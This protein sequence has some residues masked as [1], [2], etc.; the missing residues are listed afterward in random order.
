MRHQPKTLIPLFALFLLAGCAGHGQYTSEFKQ[1]AQERM[2]QLK[3]A[4][5]WDM[6][7]QQFLSGDLYKA[8]K[9]VDQS[10]TIS[11]KVAKSHLLRGRILIEMGRLEEAMGSLDKAIELKPEEAEAHYYKG[12]IFER[13]TQP[14]PALESYRAAIEHD[15]TDP[16]YVLAAAEMLIQLRKLDD[17]EQ[18]LGERQADFQHNAGIRQTL[19][20]IAMIRGDTA[21]AA[22]RFKEACTLDPDD[23]GLLEDLAGAQIA[24][25]DYAGA[26]YSLRRALADPKCKDRSD[27]KFLR[28]RA[29]MAIDKPVEAR[30]ILLSLTQEE[31]GMN[32]TRL[33]AALGEA[34]A[35]IGDPI[36]LRE[37]ATRLIGLA[38]RQPVG[39][40]LLARWQRDRGDLAVAVA[41]LDRAIEFAGADP[42]P[43]LLQGL[44][45][46]RLNQPERAASSY[47]LALA[48]DPRCVEAS[49]RLNAITS[50][51]P[52]LAGVDEQP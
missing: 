26:E 41:T 8:L 22:R 44:L 40:V 28:A 6:A 37:C 3:A 29:L 48:A 50:A 10:I 25:G 27:L 17:A 32:D 33:L 15:R 16:Q 38:P 52:A 30:D 12:I 11:D 43:A 14:E 13:F 42:G 19:G 7:H 45:Y 2:A 24:A 20:H 51:T 39:Y 1:Q 34:S 9:S 46:Q 36:R 5:Q 31:Q 35:R 18:L 23:A 47:R 49:A 21:L 4:T